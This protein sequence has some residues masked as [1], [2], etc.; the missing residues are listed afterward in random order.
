VAWIWGETIALAVSKLNSSSVDYYRIFYQALRYKTLNVTGS[1]VRALFPSSPVRPMLPFG[2][3]PPRNLIFSILLG[4]GLLHQSSVLSSADLHFCCF[5][6]L[7]FGTKGK[8]E[9]LRTRNSLPHLRRMNR[10]SK[11]TPRYALAVETRMDL[12]LAVETA[13]MTLVTIACVR[14]ILLSGVSLN[15]LT[16]T[17]GVISNHRMADYPFHQLGILYRQ[18]LT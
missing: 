11:S 2:R 3:S 15:H 17:K 12:T 1:A 4:N 8:R 13:H 9:L 16:E 5:F 14:H 10:E 7:Y 6:S 18:F